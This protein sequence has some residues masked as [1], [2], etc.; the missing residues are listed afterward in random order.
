MVDIHGTMRQLSS[1]HKEAKWLQYNVM[2]QALPNGI[3]ALPLPQQRCPHANAC[4]SCT[5]FRTHVKFLPQH[6]AQ[7]ETTNKIIETAKTNGWERQV[8]M[9][10]T[11]KQ[12]LEAVIC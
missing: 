10:M 9:N 7:L 3:C 5:H 8:E 11:V 6:Q 1:Q 12:N 2:V 4:L